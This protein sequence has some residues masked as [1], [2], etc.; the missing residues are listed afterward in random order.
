MHPH[1]RSSA[2]ALGPL[3]GGGRPV[4]STGAAL[5]NT[6]LASAGLGHLLQRSSRNRLVKAPA[7]LRRPTCRPRLLL[8]TRVG[9][10]AQ[11]AL[12]RKGVVDEGRHKLPQKTLGI[13]TK[14][15]TDGSNASSVVSLISHSIRHSLN[16]NACAV[17]YKCSTSRRAA[18]KKR[19]LWLY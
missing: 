8:R 3:S 1:D 19:N 9:F 4:R 12:L 16:S 14:K 15:Q 6:L 10:T 13:V 11:G 7:D 18:A 17:S 5:A 2:H